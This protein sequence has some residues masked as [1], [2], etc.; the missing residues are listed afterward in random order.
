MRMTAA[1]SCLL[2]IDIQQR[3]LPA[4]AEPELVTGNTAVLMRAAQ[5]LSVPVLL[6]EQYPRGL[7]PTVEQVAEFVPAGTTVA[8]EHFSCWS[9]PAWR[10]RFEGIARD[11]A[12]ICGMESHVCVMQ[13]AL[14]LL[15]AGR[16]VFVVA[17]AV[18]SRHVDSKA[19]ALDRMRDAGAAIVTTEMVVFE[20]LE[21]A[22]TAEFKDLSALIK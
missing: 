15:S 4:I 21:R 5:R 19:R 22:G 1:H 13:T 7:G 11:Q 18:S 17:D 16:R 8:K 10:E 9:E 12:V 3:L 20:W 14:D 2:V 6:S